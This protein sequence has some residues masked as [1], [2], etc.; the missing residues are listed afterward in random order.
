MIWPGRRSAEGL[1]KLV[2][3]WRN[4]DDAIAESDTEPGELLRR[5]RTLLADVS[6]AM[7]ANRRRPATSFAA[8]SIFREFGA[9][10]VTE[11]AP[12]LVVYDGELGDLPV[13]V[14]VPG[15][16]AAG[17]IEPLGLDEAAAARARNFFERARVRYLEVSS[18]TRLVHTPPG[19]GHNYP[20]ETPEV[21]V[22]VVRGLL[23]EL[24]GEG[25]TGR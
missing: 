5:Q 19:T 17:V 6:D 16:G 21:V 12:D 3:M 14:V 11:T 4:R 7:A 18:D 23:V 8:A 24:R 1:A 9:G 15:E 13:L 10:K 22:E 20:Y 25:A 2:G